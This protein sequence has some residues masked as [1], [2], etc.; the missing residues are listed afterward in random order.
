MRDLLLSLAV[1]V[2]GFVIGAGTI[3][4]LGLGLILICG[5]IYTSPSAVVDLMAG[6]PLI[7]LLFVFSC[8]AGAVFFARRVYSFRKR[9]L[10]SLGARAVQ[11][12]AAF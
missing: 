6:Y 7:L 10:V 11:Q 5:V 9:S 4:I 3:F 2:G 1:G 12:H 8:F